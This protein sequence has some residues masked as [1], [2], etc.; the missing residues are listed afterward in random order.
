[1]T[2]YGRSPWVDTFPK[3]RVPSYPRQRGPLQTSVVVIGGG[4]TGCAT[5][6]AFAANDIDVILLESDQVGRGSTG[7]AAGWISGDPGVPFAEVEKTN[8]RA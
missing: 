4:L 5:A 7:L 6:Y 2:K 8:G 1:M 3:S